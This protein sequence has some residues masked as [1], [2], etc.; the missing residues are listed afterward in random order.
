[1]MKL[2]PMNVTNKHGATCREFVVYVRNYEKL[3]LA[4][5]RLWFS[6]L[7]GF[8]FD[9]I[10]ER[11]AWTLSAYER[12]L[13]YSIHHHHNVRNKMLSYRREA[14]LQGAFVLA[15][16]GKLELGDNILRTLYY[17]SITID[18]FYRRNRQTNKRTDTFSSLDCVCIPCSAVKTVLFIE[19]DELHKYNM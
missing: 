18:A 10:C 19:E 8:H 2:L 12:R 1:M 7:L 9:I 13:N 15:K 5:F 4:F 17:R 3:R 16:S 6:S 14:A 11:P